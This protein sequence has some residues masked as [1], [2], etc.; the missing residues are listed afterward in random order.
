MEFLP[1]QGGAT[2]LLSE[3]K[4]KNSEQVHP[5]EASVLVR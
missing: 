2:T 5:P 4:E 1:R 3:E